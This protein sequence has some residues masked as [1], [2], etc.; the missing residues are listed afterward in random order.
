MGR[1]LKYRRD[2]LARAK[3]SARDR[4]RW[5]L[6]GQSEALAALTRNAHRPE[7]HRGRKYC[8][9]AAWLEQ[10]A[11]HGPG[12]AE[13][14]K[15]AVTPALC[16]CW[17]AGRD[18]RHGDPRCAARRPTVPPSSGPCLPP[19]RLPPVNPQWRTAAVQALCAAVVRTGQADAL[20]VLADALEE[21]GCDHAEVLTH[22]RDR[23]VAHGRA[24]WVV[25]WLRSEE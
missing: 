22:C 13:V 8:A 15:R 14:G 7:L 23:A 1:G 10:V 19:V 2:Q 6:A 25:G 21:A 12:P 20:A 9:L 3:A 18:W 24:C 17:K 11:E 5:L 16:S 4:V